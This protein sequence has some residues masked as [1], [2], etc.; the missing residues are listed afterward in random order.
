MQGVESSEDKF[1]KRRSSVHAEVAAKMASDTG[2]DR[3]ND[4]GKFF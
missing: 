2:N 1:T 3:G 4:R